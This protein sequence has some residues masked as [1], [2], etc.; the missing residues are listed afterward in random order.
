M[1]RSSSSSGPP[2]RQVPIRKSQRV[3]LW[4]GQVGESSALEEVR[5][6]YRY[7]DLR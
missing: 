6:R 5:L 7:V 4:V 1:R 3:T 2:T